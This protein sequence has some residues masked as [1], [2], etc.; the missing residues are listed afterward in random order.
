MLRRTL[1]LAAAGLKLHWL[2]EEDSQLLQRL[3]AEEVLHQ[4]F[5]DLALQEPEFFGWAFKARK[6]MV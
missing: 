2:Q 6:M 4:G 5:E 1:I 3:A